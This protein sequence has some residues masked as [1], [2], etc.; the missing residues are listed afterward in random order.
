MFFVTS[1][2]WQKKQMVGAAATAHI[3]G[4]KISDDNYNNTIY[5]IIVGLVGRR[6]AELPGGHGTA[7]LLAKYG[8]M[9][10]ISFPK[11]KRGNHTVK[12]WFGKQRPLSCRGADDGGVVLVFQAGATPV[13]GG[14]RRVKRE[15]KREGRLR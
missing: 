11:W 14:F 2:Q 9:N 13:G 4:I 7:W 12:E 1:S 6:N 8:R 3:N 15:T 10:S 5:L